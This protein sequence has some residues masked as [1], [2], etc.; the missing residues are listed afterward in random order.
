MTRQQDSVGLTTF[1]TDVRLD[2]PARSSPRHFNEM[3]RQL[4][5]IE[6]GRQTNIAGTLHKLAA[7][8]KRRCLIVLISDLYDEPEEVIRALHHFRH[9]RHE[10]ILF[11][12][13]D[14]AELEFP[15]KDV[16]AFHDMETDERIQVDPAYVR[17]AYI[18]QVNAF[19]DTY[20]RACAETQ[21]DYVMTDT[22]V[23]Y[24]FMLSKYIAKRNR[25]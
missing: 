2:M 13:F 10:V 19:I 9:R 18:E 20:R 14:K 12:V 15:F 4:E 11:H 17:E 16:I 25:P 3:M 6:P 5:A 22:S 8:F 7:R 24:D 1:D 21:I 23:P